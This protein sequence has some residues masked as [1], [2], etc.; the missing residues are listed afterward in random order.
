[1]T[2]KEESYPVEAAEPIGNAPNAVTKCSNLSKV[3][4]NRAQGEVCG[5]WGFELF[6]VGFNIQCSLQS[7]YLSVQKQKQVDEVLHHPI[8]TRGYCGPKGTSRSDKVQYRDA[9]VD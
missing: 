9:E 2:V 1:M 5:K 6:E 7:R 3:V 8:G 4:H